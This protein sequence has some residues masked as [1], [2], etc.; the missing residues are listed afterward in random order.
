[1]QKE[2]VEMAIE[3]VRKY[4]EKYGIEDRILEFD[5][6]SATVELAAKAVGVEGARICKTLS[7]KDGDDGCILI[8]TAGDTKIDNRKFK[9]TFGQKAKMLTAEEVVEFTGHAIGGVCAF[10]I[11]NPKVRVY[12]DESLRRFETVFPA[13][14]SSNSA[15]EFTCDELYKYSQA[16]EWIDV[17][18]I[19]EPNP[20]V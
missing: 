18:K 1:M 10:A 19:P 7:F 20:E 13:C 2:V 6:S 5:V 9:D 3:K 15:I 17:C 14:G 12:C 8:Q 4:F 11:E 16:L